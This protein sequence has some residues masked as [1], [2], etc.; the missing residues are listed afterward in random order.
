MPSD[1]T[2]HL[3]YWLR[4]VSNHVSGSFAVALAERSV[5]VPEW[6]LL[7][8]LHDAPARPSA[9][10]QEMGFTRGAVSKLA[11]RLISR[12]LL[13]RTASD[14]DGRAQ[15]LVLSDDG[16]RLVPDL[17]AIADANDRN[18]FDVLSVD[19]RNTLERLLR[20]IVEAKG[21]KTVPT[22]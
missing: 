13:D 8:L 17:A 12:G 22:D 5:T 15:L 10:A 19:E 21:L 4:F 14:E 18:A 1:L 20:K 2:A 16:R 7:R 9:I 6:V 3:G 11:D